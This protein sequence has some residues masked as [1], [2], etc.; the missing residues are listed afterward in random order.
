[1]ARTA[2]IYAT[3]LGKHVQAVAEYI[4]K[5]LDADIFNLKQQMDIELSGFDRIILGTGVHAGR[6]YSKMNEFVSTHRE[7]ID[8][9]KTSLFVC[10]MYNNEKGS[11]QAAKIADGYQVHD[12]TFFPDG[13]EKNADGVFKDV[14]AFVERMR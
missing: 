12:V 3:S 14:V 1:M 6:P 8:S 13:G 11:M 9:K 5:E 7:E 4:A 10:C 2:V